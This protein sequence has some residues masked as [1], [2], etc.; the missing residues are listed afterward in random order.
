MSPALN[1]SKAI[2][3]LILRVFFLLSKLYLLK[4]DNSMSFRIKSIWDL[5]IILTS[6]FSRQVDWKA[7][8]LDCSILL[9][10]YGTF[11]FWEVLF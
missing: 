11:F 9:M 1:L 5:C 10:G 4:Q 8:E 6:M 2:H 3:F 7:G